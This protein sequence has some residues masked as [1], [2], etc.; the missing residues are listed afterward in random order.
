MDF[1]YIL[2]CYRLYTERGDNR[3]LKCCFPE[4]RLCRVFSLVAAEVEGDLKFVCSGRKNT[5]HKRERGAVCE[6]TLLV[7]V[8]MVFIFARVPAAAN[9]CY[10]S[11]PLADPVWIHL[12]AAFSLLPSTYFK[13]NITELLKL[14]SS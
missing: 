9:C 6:H 1:Y 2:F 12:A 3:R 8:G 4:L 5:H 7:F 10:T 11:F 14:R 13:P